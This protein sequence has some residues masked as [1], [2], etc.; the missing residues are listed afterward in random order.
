VSLPEAEWHWRA[1]PRAGGRRRAATA[2]RVPH[3]GVAYGGA[4]VLVCTEGAYEG[5]RTGAAAGDA[6]TVQRLTASE[7]P[8]LRCGTEDRQAFDTESTGGSPVACGVAGASL[9]Q[10]SYCSQPVNGAKSED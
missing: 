7:D 5:M 8:G 2:C 10:H 6:T 3:G 9:T 1:V 4:R